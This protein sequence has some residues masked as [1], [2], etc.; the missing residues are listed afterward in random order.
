MKTSK[1]VGLTMAFIAVM[2]TKAVGNVV[3]NGM[4]WQPLG[5]AQLNVTSNPQDELQVTGIGSSGN[6]GVRLLVPNGAPSPNSELGMDFIDLGNP[7]NYS[8]GAF[9]Q[10]TAWGTINDSTGQVVS[11]VKGTFN[12]SGMDISVNLTPLA[13]TSLTADYYFRGTLVLSETDINP[14]GAAMTSCW[15]LNSVKVSFPPDIELNWCRGS[16]NV[17]TFS[18]TNVTAD[19]VM[20]YPQNL[21]NELGKYTAIDLTGADIGRLTLPEPATMALL[22]LGGL[23]LLRRRK[24]KTD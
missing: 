11:T 4:E 3:F 20:V 16:P 9:I 10:M 13:P 17:Q 2:S 12:G 8:E 6:D 21:G 7:S 5:Q 1:I 14:V 23:A 19:L 18:G 15:G 24:G 22:G